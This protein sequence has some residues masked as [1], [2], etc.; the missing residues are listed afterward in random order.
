[1]KPH[2]LSAVGLVLLVICLAVPQLPVPEYWITLLNYTGIYA[3]PVL[4]LVLLTGFARITTLGQA[5][6]VGIGSYATAVLA[7]KFNISP[8]FGLLAGIALAVLIAFLIGLVTMRLSGHFLTLATLAWGLALFYLFGNMEFL[9]K[10]D[11][12]SGLPALHVFGWELASPRQ[13]YYLIWI[14]LIS[15]MLGVRNLLNS[16]IGRA[17]HTLKGGN[18]LAEAMGINSQWLKMLVFILAA[19]LAAISGFLY[20]GLQRAVNPTSFGINYGIEYLFMAVIGGMGQ[21]WGALIGAAVITIL[22]DVLQS[23][24]PRLIGEQANYEMVVLGIVMVLILHYSRDGVWGYISRLLPQRAQTQAPDPQSVEPLPSRRRTGDSSGP[25]LEVRQARKTFGELV[26]VNDVSFDVGPREIV[27]LIGPNGAGKSTLFNLVSGVLAL[28]SGEIRFC[29]ER[30]DGRSSRQI[31]Y[32]GVGRTFQH[33]KLLPQM[34]VLENV[35]VGA[36]L[37]GH[38]GPL[39]AVLRLDRPDEK[40]LLAEAARQIERVGLTGAMYTQAGNLALGQQR[41]VEIA[42]ALA[43]DPTLLLL[44][45]PAAG[46]RYMEKKALA[47]LLRKLRDEG[48]SILLVEHDMDFVMNLTDRLVVM[49]Y[50]ARIAS[51][52][53]QQV[54]QDPAVLQA[55][56][57]G[58]A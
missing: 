45:E 34:T 36:H 39:R 51:G 47:D 5:A 32:Q 14:V 8:W 23:M 38:S 25:L 55:Y 11:G 4:G 27:G 6:F 28:N 3:L 29:G 56:L 10:Y 1:M 18:V 52:T 7:V 22:K 49:E 57:G 41:V 15:S 58:M 50:G 20:A 42:R 37:R 17:I 33:V 44:D 2:H 16:R 19:V 40:R 46:L 53:P 43:G 30:I 24:L 9:G 21:V 26:A 12:L 54:Q 13:M 31:V 48:M 35:A